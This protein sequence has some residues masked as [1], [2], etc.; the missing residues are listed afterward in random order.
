V[1][2]L[3]NRVIR[4]ED[5]KFLTVGGTYTADLEDPRLDGAG[6]V[7][8]VRSTMA[9]A[10]LRSVDVSEARQA[11]G[12]I[13]VFTADDLTDVT[14]MPPAVPAFPA[15]M[16]DRP[17]LAGDAVHF[18]GESVAV[19]VTERPEQGEDAAELVVIDY[20]PLTAVVDMLEAGSD[21]TLVHPDA[22]TN[23]AFQI[24]SP[25]SDGL[26][27]GCEVVVEGTFLNQRLAACP[28]EVRSS[29]ATWDGD[30]LVY[31]GST[32]TPNAVKGVLTAIYGGDP[33]VMSPD[34]GGGFG[35]KIGMYPDEALLPWIAK[36]IGRPVRWI[37]T[38][39]ENMVALYHGRGQ[40][41][42]AT[43]GGS[44]DGKVQAYRLDV[45]G[46]AGAYAT[47]G[48]FLPALT[49]LMVQGVY[50]IPRVECGVK[51]VITNTT[52]THA[53][54]GAGRPEAT[55]AVER[56]M[57]LFAAEIGMDP[58]EVRRRNLIPDD[59]FPF[60]TKVDTVYDIGGYEGSLD[61]ALA[62]ADYA[63]L[64][65]EQQRRRDAGEVR[66]L[67]IGVSVYV[68]ITAGPA[69]VGAE[70][71]KV[72]VN[73]DGSATVYTGTS[74]HGQGHATSWSMLASDQLGIPM[75]RITVIHGDTDKVKDGVGTFG[76]RSLQVGG[77]AVYQA[78]GEVA[79]KAKKIAAELLEANP[80]DVVLDVD[81]GT[82]HVAGTPAVSKSWQ[83]V[84][85]AAG[86]GDLLVELKYA[87]DM[88]SFPFGTHIA[89]VEVDTETGEVDF[90]RMVTCDDAGRLVNPLLA[91]GQRHG[92]IAQGSAQALLEEVRYD[93]DGNPQTANFMDYAIISATELPSFELEVQETPTPVNVLGAKGI[94]ESGTIGAAP[95][96]QSAIIDAVSH[97]GVRHIDMPCTPQRVWAAIQGAR[98]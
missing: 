33:H 6:H 12:V 37:E 62:A 80:D 91:E 61:K 58:A 41:Q 27:E 60:T 82:F 98:G 26:F 1:S 87:G 28:L 15:S 21:A 43:I 65:A 38:R 7:T 18:V 23:V 16:Q 76:S 85:G 47:M 57:D 39:S 9:S 68:E 56:A 66:Q 8:Y 64:R 78:A 40:V 84:A 22:G 49:R 14:P 90:V 55:A 69:P 34:V 79:D 42:R 35:P 25:N 67:G 52:P 77:S 89:V 71:A 2:I 46:D 20:E 13:A 48:A 97:L 24:P 32:Q 4:K 53:Y 44:R 63:G 86:E 70:W 29:A 96:L 93:A 94:G 19:V 30:R 36:R 45:V 81:N 72:E 59:A 75:D 92:G 74:P 83:D 51:S 95:A 10:R 73:G 50:D 54:R 3:G 88:P 5:P 11:E 17:Y 31:W